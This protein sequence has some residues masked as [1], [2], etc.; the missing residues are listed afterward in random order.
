M[1]T[2][3]YFFAFGLVIFTTFYCSNNQTNQSHKQL[4]D[5]QLS[6]QVLIDD[7]LSDEQILKMIKS[8]YTVYIVE[9]AEGKLPNA[10]KLDSIRQIYCTTALLRSIDLSE[11]DPLL[12]AQDATIE[13]LKTLSIEKDP[14]KRNWYNVS[15]IDNFNGEK[16]IIE[17]KIIKEKSFYKIDSIM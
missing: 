15:Y 6:D 2:K 14:Q 7:K 10:A 5:K 13:W 4:S 1:K 11:G 12:K 9:A 8:F 3:L 16:V 17:L